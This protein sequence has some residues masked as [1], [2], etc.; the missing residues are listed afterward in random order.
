MGVLSVIL[1]VWIRKSKITINQTVNTLQVTLARLDVLKERFQE[2][3]ENI[4]KHMPT[5]DSR[6]EEEENQIEQIEQID[7][8]ISR[9]ETKKSK[10]PW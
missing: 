7:K 8:P 2:Q 1:C 4:P 10:L 5:P 6:K 9:P 3:Q